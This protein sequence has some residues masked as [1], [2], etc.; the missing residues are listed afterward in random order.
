MSILNAVEKSRSFSVRVLTKRVDQFI[1]ISDF[2]RLLNGK[3]EAYDGAIKMLCGFNEKSEVSKYRTLFGS[4]CNIKLLNAKGKEKTTGYMATGDVYALYDSKGNIV[5]KLIVIVNGDV[6]G[7][8]KVNAADYIAQRRHIL[9]IIRLDT[10]YFTAADVNGNGKV[11]AND[12]IK[13][14]RF[15]LGFINTLD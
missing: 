3:E 12:Y 15:L 5:D 8:D 7:D 4:R 2:Q 9:G 14:R 13:L 11:Q 6:N 1:L 10:P